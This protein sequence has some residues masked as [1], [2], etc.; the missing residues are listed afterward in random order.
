MQLT[1]PADIW[2]AVGLLLDIV[3][4]V[5]LFFV[6]PEKYPDPQSSAFFALEDK[7]L[8][9]RW[10]K[11]QRRRRCAAIMGVVMISFGFVFQGVAVLFF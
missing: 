5:L 3:G 11:N 4:I 2:I 8:R 7:K 10:I 1:I 9:P 6:V